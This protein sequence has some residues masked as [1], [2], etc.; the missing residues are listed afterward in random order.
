MRR[1]QEKEENCMNFILAL[2]PIVW[3]IV[4][5]S[6]IKLPGYKAC[7]I[8]LAV[9]AVEGCFIFGLTPVE[10]LTAALEGIL[11][12][13]WPIILVII[14]ALF[15][16]NMT[17]E[18]GAMEDIKRMLGSLSNDNRILML[19]IA[20]GFGNFME[21]MAG[22]GTAV[23][24]PAGM[25]VGV[26]FDPILAVVACLV[27]N[28][29][30]TVFGSVG[31]PAT[32]LAGIAGL[33]ILTLTRYAATIQFVLTFLSPFLAVIIIGGGLK[34]MKGMFPFTLI[35]SLSFVIPQFLTAAF[36]GAELPNILGSII[37]MVIMVAAAKLLP[38]QVEPEYLITSSGKKEQPMTLQKG[39]T[40]WAPFIFTF[41]FLLLTSN[42]VP[43]I[44][45]PLA[46][47]KSSVQVYA[48]ENPG[49][50]NFFWV[51]TP[52]IIIFI[53]SFC[54]SLIQKASPATMWKVLCRTVKNNVKTILTV[55]SVLAVAKIMGYSG[56]ISAIA[57]V[58]V[59]VTGS[60]FPLFSPLIGVIG[61]FVTGSGT[62]TAV[63]FGSLQAQTAQQIGADP[64]WLCAA[65]EMGGGVGK[66][67]C[68]Q[69]I[70]IGCAA[71]GIVGSESKILG[72]AFIYCLLYA[73]LGGLIC[74]FFPILGLV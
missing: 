16:Y 46:A 52:G 74:F 65:N 33:D 50:L 20:W 31:V 27:I 35:A 1:I 58:L 15:T 10:T 40:A 7:L 24:I 60:F 56:M 5:M 28:S 2:V 42:L 68:P 21:G 54:G 63:L 53:A 32:T 39:L 49:T 67:L 62:S 59:R 14:A 23:A 45:D 11:N 70:A 19:I 34:A 73:V 8:A 69:S 47:I 12:A 25:L 71:V 51:N 3:L 4:A 6:V 48:G 55:C 66:M 44:H 37:S 13:L 26:G 9:A 41:L 18:T 29:T 43:V 22:F 38:H 30:P 17:L 61:G 36:I 72:K 57:A 64:A